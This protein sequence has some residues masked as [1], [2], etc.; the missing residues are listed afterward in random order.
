MGLE[1]ELIDPFGIHVDSHLTSMNSNEIK[2]DHST[3]KLLNDSSDP[4][5][6]SQ[7]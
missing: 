5:Q 7:G 3:T 2:D 4:I 6:G 1:A